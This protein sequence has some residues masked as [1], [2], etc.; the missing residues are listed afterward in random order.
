MVQ[1]A[2]ST[3]SVACGGLVSAAVSRDIQPASFEGKGP[4]EVLLAALER[5]GD[6]LRIA[7]SF[8]IEDMVVV[9]EAARAGRE[10]GQAPRVFLLDTGRLYQETFDLLDRVRTRYDVSVDVFMPDAY[11]VESLVRSKGPNSFYASLENRKE[12]CAIRKLDPLAKALA[13]ARAWATGLRR[14]QSPT[15]A[16]IASA[17]IDERGLLKLNPLAT[18][19]EANVWDFAREHDVPIHA[20]HHAGYTSIG[21]AP[22]TRAVLPGEHARAGRWWWESPEHKECGL[23][24]RKRTP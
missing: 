15:R 7:C 19:T 12:C 5:F 20:L 17:E 11:Q 23:H 4:Y 24:A 18:W 22:C 9:H 14:E 8:S 3:H 10:L 21:C 6:D 2:P 16:D 1:A 13:G